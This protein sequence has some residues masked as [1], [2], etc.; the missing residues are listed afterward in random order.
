V[1]F[2]CRACHH[3]DGRISDEIGHDECHNVCL[4]ISSNDILKSLSRMI[5]SLLIPSRPNAI[6]GFNSITDLEHQNFIQG[7]DLTI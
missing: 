5:K 4:A 7:H 6:S 1:K 2:D 3:N